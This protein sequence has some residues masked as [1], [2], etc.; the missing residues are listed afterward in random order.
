MN[1]I[2]TFAP[3]QSLAAVLIRRRRGLLTA[4]VAVVALLGA[5]LVCHLLTS[6]PESHSHAHVGMT[7]SQVS[8]EHEH[9]AGPTEIGCAPHNGHCVP[10]VVLPARI[11]DPFVIGWL[12]VLALAAVVAVSVPVSAGR[13]TRG[14]PV[15]EVVAAVSG[16]EILNR[17]CIARR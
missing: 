17:F 5:L 9:A 6:G 2:R 11:H 10:Q 3:P 7:V 4:A 13:W 14:P 16:R 12:I 1:A 15:G 8:G